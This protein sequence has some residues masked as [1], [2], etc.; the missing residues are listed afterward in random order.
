M[1]EARQLA[2]AALE[3]AKVETRFSHSW[4]GVASQA[5]PAET[6]SAMSDEAARAILVYG[7]QAQLYSDFYCAGAARPAVAA[8]GSGG[9]Q[10]LTPFMQALSDANAGAGTRESSWTVVAEDG[11]ELVVSRAG[12]GVRFWASPADV[13]ASDNPRPGATIGLTMP[14]ELL[15][16][17]P[18]FYMALGNAELPMDGSAP[19]LRIYWNLH[20]AGAAPLTAALTQELNRASVPFRFKVVSEPQRFNRCDAAVLYLQRSDYVTT[21]AIVATVYRRIAGFLEPSV[22]ALTKPL[23]PGLGLAED[24]GIFVS[25]G[26]SR[27]YLLA[28]AI[29]RAAERHATDPATRLEVAEECFAETGLTLGTPYLEAGS[30]DLYAFEA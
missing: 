25:F 16:L 2:A 21:A 15:R 24:P 12:V 3:A 18:G 30:T 27:C 28:E 14:K 5:V 20:S 29:V 1:N 26:M 22:P 11:D 8:G 13:I 9:L 19:L 23:A 7:L 10:V 17:S 4:F 6:A